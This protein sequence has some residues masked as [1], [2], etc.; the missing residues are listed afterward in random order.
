MNVQG[1][2]PPTAEPTTEAAPVEPAWSLAE[3]VEEESSV[4]AAEGAKEALSSQSETV[5]SVIDT[6]DKVALS[7]GDFRI[8]LFDVLIVSA[9]IIGVLVFAWF[10]SRMARRLVKRMT[11]LDDAQQL[12]VEK[13]VTIIVWAAAFFI[14]IDL[15][16]IDLTA[17]AV[18][19]GAFGLAIGFGLQKTFGNL[20]A[21]II[22]LMDRSI[23]PG[24]VI[25]VADLAGNESFGQIRK[26]GIRAVSVTTRDG[27]T[28]ARSRAQFRPGAQRP[29]ADR[30]D[31][32]IWRQFG[33]FRDP[34]LDQGSRRRRRQRTQRRAQE[35]VA[36]VQGQR[37]RNSL[38]AA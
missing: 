34:L 16:G 35:A 25:A 23:K 14:G 32:R 27:G 12:L 9:V 13:I 17:L 33:Q 11:R 24:D 26:I 4:A 1:P 22:L 10:A 2:T 36:A 31:E 7:L 20:I 30:V 21:G 8:S 28:D 6:V 3:P 19:S 38:S 37:D 29:A 5:G 18:F 15:L